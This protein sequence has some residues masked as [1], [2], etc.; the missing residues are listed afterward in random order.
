MPENLPVEKHIKDVKKE[1]KQFKKVE[2]KRLK[3]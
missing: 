3:N 2:V 1:L